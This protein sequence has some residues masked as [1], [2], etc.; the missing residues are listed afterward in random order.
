MSDAATADELENDEEDTGKGGGLKKILMIAVPVVLLLGGGGAAFMLGLF[1]GGSSGGVDAPAPPKRVYFMDLPELTVNL[2]SVEQR[3]QYLKLSVSLEVSN[4]ATI[5]I[6][7][8]FLP[9]VLDAF[10]VYLREVR[11]SD[12]EGSAGVFLLKEE[13]Q[14]R[15]ELAIHPAKIDDIL[16]K[17]ILIQ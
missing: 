16:F 5:G 1:G 17:E 12:L 3:A 14:R 15:I 6:I 7:E 13:L 11:T 2:S 9:R 10:Q 8:P 4:E